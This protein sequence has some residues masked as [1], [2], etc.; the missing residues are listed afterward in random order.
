MQ[1]TGQK[2]SK[3]QQGRYLATISRPLY[4]NEASTNR[5]QERV[6]AFINNNRDFESFRIAAREMELPI[7]KANDLELHEWSIPSLGQ[8]SSLAALIRWAHTK[9]KIGVVAPTYYNVYKDRL[10]SGLVD[11]FIVPVVVYLGKKETDNL[12]RPSNKIAAK[13]ILQKEK[14]AAIVSQKIKELHSLETIATTYGVSITALNIPTINVEK[15]YFKNL[16]QEPMVASVLAVTKEGE[17]SRP[18]KGI[19]G[20][21]IIEVEDR[22]PFGESSL[23]KDNMI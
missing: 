10:N 19:K 20:V 9:A 18:I 12:T 16:Q 22:Q 6:N 3:T 5:A 1:I 11:E 2:Y 13:L 4:P 14:K 7:E 17:L 8:N 23:E 21:Y 15:K